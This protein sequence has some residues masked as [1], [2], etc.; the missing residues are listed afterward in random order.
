MYIHNIRSITIS[1]LLLAS[2]A[3]GMD[4][5]V[6]TGI[7]SAYSELEGVARSYDVDIWDGRT[8]VL[9]L[10]VIL[11][12]LNRHMITLHTDLPQLQNQDE[13]FTKHHAVLCM[14]RSPQMVSSLER[15]VNAMLEKQSR[16]R[17]ISQSERQY[18]F[19]L[20]SYA[21]NSC[22]TKLLH[23]GAFPEQSTLQVLLKHGAQSHC[24][25]YSMQYSKA[26]SADILVK[27]KSSVRKKTTKNE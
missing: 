17:I 6:V 18:M 7:Q 13:F 2:T 27:S 9:P 12:E 1:L 3:Q 14:P 11:I 4:D 24:I 19:S 5:S 23:G 20:L 22:T 16:L 21:A 15:L 10:A 25:T 26:H 8:I